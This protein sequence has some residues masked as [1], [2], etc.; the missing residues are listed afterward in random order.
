MHLNKLRNIGII[1]HIDAGKTTVTERILFYTGYLRKMG[2]VHNGEATMDF[3]KQEQERGITIASAAITC[4]WQDHQINLIDTPGHVDF[5]V[6]VERSLRVLDGVVAV[7]C[8]V[9]GV[10]P[11]TETVWSQAQRHRVPVIAFVNKMDVPGADFN[12]CIRSI[13]ERLEAHP[14]AFQLPIFQGEEFAGAVDLVE[15]KA[16]LFESGSYVETVIP[17]D[18]VEAAASKR[19]ELIER[20]ADCDDRLIEEYISGNPVSSSTIRDVARR[21]VI[22][23]LITPVFCGA[24]YKNRG[25]QPLLSAIVDYL[26]SPIDRGE[27]V[28]WSLDGSEKVHRRN[29]EEGDPFAAL[30]FKII[31]D[32]YVGQQT[33]IRI[34]SG[35]ISKGDTVRNPGKGKS[36]RI[37]RILR[38]RAKER[39]ELDTASAGDIVGLVGMKYT[40]TGDTLCSPGHQL[41]LETI[42]VPE[43]VIS[44]KAGVSSRQERIIS[45]HHSGSL[46]WKILPSV[47][48]PMKRQKKL[49]YRGWESF[50]SRLSSIASGRNSA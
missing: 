25:I 49:S 34:Y 6:E 38:I 12:A 35:A 24:A 19:T 23:S 33:F 29:P 9:N 32:P 18:M 31:H 48:A 39:E 1:A 17:P 47:S 28:G 21:C 5:M 26:P 44:V 15:M 10:E 8:A 50:T 41:I 45:H 30:A 43:A 37:G 14:I 7:F 22:N 2:E 46:Q 11:Q 16:W 13:E 42:S 36:E 40:N 27:M 4:S 3:M 20:L